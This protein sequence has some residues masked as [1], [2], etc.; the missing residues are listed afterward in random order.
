MKSTANAGGGVLTNDLSLREAINLANSGCVA[1]AVIDFA[2]GPFVTDTPIELASELPTITCPTLEIRGERKVSI[3]PAYG[4]YFSESSC[5]INS[6]P[7]AAGRPRLSGLRVS[8][9][10]NRTAICG[11]V[12]AIDNKIHGNNQGFAISDSVLANNE[13]YSNLAGIYWYG[14]TAASMTDNK[15]HD[16]AYGS[17]YIE[18]SATLDNN[19][20][21]NNGGTGVYVQGDATLRNNKVYGNSDRGIEVEGAGT[22]I[23]NIVYGHAYNGIV[24]GYNSVIQ[25][26]TV[27]NNYLN[28]YLYGGTVGGDS[29]GDG[30]FV[31]SS[32]GESGIWASPVEGQSVT[33]RNNVV[34]KAEA[35]GGNAWGIYV[36][37]NPGTVVVSD[38]IVV[39]NDNSIDI[40]WAQHLTLDGNFVGVHGDG[41]TPGSN[42]YGVY[43]EDVGTA[44]ITNNTLSASFQA[45]GGSNGIDLG[46]INQATVSGNHI[47]LSKN[48]DAM[49]G[50][51][52]YGLNAYCVSN[53]SV[54]GNAVSNNLYG[55][56]LIESD[57]GNTLVVSD[58]LVGVSGA[59]TPMPNGTSDGVQDGG[60]LLYDAWCG[61][62]VA[63]DNY[64]GGAKSVSKGARKAKHKAKGAAGL[65]SAS[66]ARQKGITAT[67]E[68]SNN[69]VAYN[70]GPGITAESMGGY[71][72]R[73]GS[74]HSN[75][76]KNIDLLGEV[77]GQQTAPSISNVSHDGIS[78]TFTY[79]VNG[80]PGSYDIDFYENYFPQAGGTVYLGTVTVNSDES[81]ATFTKTVTPMRDFIAATATGLSGTSE[82]SSSSV[83]V[84]AEFVPAFANLGN[85][86]VGQTSAPAA[87]IAIRSIGSGTYQIFGMVAATA[88]PVS[89]QGITTFSACSGTEFSCSTN[90]APTQPP[91]A[92]SAKNLPYNDVCTISNIT[93]SP[94]TVGTQTP[95]IYICDNT[96]AAPRAIPLSGTG[97]PP[98]MVTASPV[99]QTFGDVF[100]GQ[101]GSRTVTLRNE[102]PDFAAT[103][104]SITVTPPFSLGNDGCGG[105]VPLGGTCTLQILFT[106]TAAGSASGS[107]TIPVSNAGSPSPVV[108]NVEGNGRIESSV[109]MTSLVDLGSAV[110]G[111]NP[112]SQTVTVTNTGNGPL[113]IGSIVATPPFAATGCASP[114][115]PAPSPNT[116]TI[117]V[118]FPPTTYGMAAGTLTLNSNAPGSPNTASLQANVNSVAYAMTP[119]SDNFGAQLVGTASAARTF[120][121]QNNGVN[122]LPLNGAMVAGDYQ[123]ASNACTTSLAPGA[124]CDLGVQ[125]L[126]TVAGT[127]TGLVSVPVNYPNAP[128]AQ[129]AL[130]GSGFDQQTFTLPP[131]IAFNGATLGGNT[132]TFAAQMT[133]TGSVPVAITSIFASSPFAQGNNC[134]TSLAARASCTITVSFPPMSFGTTTG[135]LSVATD[136]PGGTRIVPI[137][138]SVNAVPYSLA[139]LSEAFGLQA[140][141][142]ESAPRAFTLSNS[143][144]NP[145]ALG[146][147]GVPAHFRLASTTCAGS[148]PANGSCVLNVSFKPTATGA[149]QGSV[150]VPVALTNAP[151]MSAGVSGEG[152]QATVVL[153]ATLN[154]G[155]A[156]L[157]TAPLTGSVQLT[158]GGNI[159]LNISSIAASPPFT[160]S[161]ACPA[162][163]APGASCNIGASLNPIA[164]GAFSG[165]ITVHSD[166]PGSPHGVLLQAN[167]SGIPYEL[168]PSV[169]DFG[170]Q[171][172]GTASAPASF[173][174]N[175]ASDMALPLGAITLSGPYAVTSTTCAALLAA[176]TSCAIDVSHKPTLAGSNTG[177]LSVPVNVGGVAPA[178]ATLQ[179]NGVLEGELAAMPTGI[180]FGV[181]SLAGPVLHKPV[182]VKNVG[183][184][185]VDFSSIAASSPFVL[186]N[187]C[188]A[189]LAPN[190]TCTLGLSFPP[191]TFGN[192]TGQLTIASNAIGGNRVITLL[193]TVDRVAYGI[194]PSTQS[195]GSQAVGS[196]SAPLPF[197][198]SNNGDA[199]I[200][201]GNIALAGPFRVTSSD[202]GASLGPRGSCLLNVAFEPTQPGPA[203]GELTVQVALTGAPP[204][205]ATF[206]GAGTQQPALALPSSLDFGT[207]VLGA[208]GPVMQT[209]EVRNT[210]NAVLTFTVALTSPSSSAFTLSPGSCGLNLA[211]GAA[212]NMLVTFT[213]TGAGDF[214]GRLV[215]TSNASTVERFINL[216]GRAQPL[217]TPRVQLSDNVLG[218]ADQPMLSQGASPQTVV[219]SNVGG[220]SATLSAMVEV[221]GILITRNTCSTTLAV[222]ATCE[223]DLKLQPLRTGPN[224]VIFRFNSDTPAP[225]G[226]HEVTLVGRGCTLRP[227]SNRSGAP[228]NTCG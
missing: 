21:Y 132:Q 78:T 35:Y 25:K 40:Y 128:P 98:V 149:L 136:A 8:G 126:P 208:G 159:A 160:A 195:F 146:S 66:K 47:G 168:T 137:T 100:V 93:F 119:A 31:H 135:N 179:G 171:R 95:S 117:T 206:S 86:V 144:P 43:I 214:T 96:G 162:S 170:S 145:I 182:E 44:I 108:A 209:L 69:T 32:T 192:V 203:E 24:A 111:A 165:T 3:V 157:G 110:L 226:L 133:N 81:P 138:A 76:G 94:S 150:A 4:G 173:L 185:N 79:S 53:L 166:A 77:L 36:D 72:I 106:P 153:P 92:F 158:N 125:F 99:S 215:V 198:L 161:P 155:A 199:A 124:F 23:S 48:R 34:G 189:S 134:G 61:E 13:V 115:N 65:K 123:F 130:T 75:T 50:N 54:T 49:R 107:I 62:E 27:Y 120:R 37:G 70:Y 221:P 225:G 80:P 90:C 26:N 140:V 222:G 151:A 63:L 187:G 122:P 41:S 19:E 7:V 196:R 60:I 219:V 82:F 129:S 212:C 9:F 114:V 46:Y 45:Y 88:A 172:V 14:G 210:G 194:G 87:P 224:S 113:I 91:Q 193:A 174:L 85:V 156:I 33:I 147:F 58:N 64:E 191:F 30:N 109:A 89:C 39:G 6:Q 17:L 184:A 183:N 188:P 190:G 42:R 105:T 38:N 52:N 176:R 74:I 213:P 28:I 56:M 205:R 116:C 97:V 127:R 84:G 57:V 12:D 143:A 10:T 201:L 68:L 228:R 141:G 220:A 164:L 202:C 22:I 55:G 71:M 163:L 148:I 118:T 169:V 103:L 1:G 104:G 152:G 102:S 59:G 200:P 139:P 197:T 142:T 121:L 5:V 217:P 218:F 20:I 175:N 216:V 177:V 211:A 83:G 154:L 181:T 207:L 29:A 15:V 67:R 131:S 223:V 227:P 112:L 180:D 18:A 178:Q 204:A 101:V 186:A 2:S 11:K 73:G 167:V 16:N 51:Q